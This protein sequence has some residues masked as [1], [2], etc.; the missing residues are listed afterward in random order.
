MDY[1][2]ICLNIFCLIVQSSMHIIFVSRFIGKKANIRYW[3]LYFFLLCVCEW[4]AHRM[5]FVWGVAIGIEL[6]ILY[7]VIRFVMN[8][9]NL[10]SW[11]SAILSIYISQLSFGLVNA[12]EAMLFYHFITQPVL[13]VLI[14]LATILALLLCGVCYYVVLKCVSFSEG[15]QTTE[16][17]LLLFPI[18][19]FFL[20][21]LYIM[22]INYTQVV[23]F[24]EMASFLESGKHMILFSLQAFGL[25]ALLCTL[26]SYRA[27][28]RGLQAK[29]T[30]SAVTQAAHAQKVYIA[31]AKMRLEK[32]RAFRHDINHHLSVLSGLCNHGNLDEVKRYL[33]K[34]NFAAGA[35]SFPYQTGN[36]IVDILLSEKLDL[37]KANQ[38]ETK[39]LLRL[40]NPCGVDDFDL[41]IIFANALDNA[42]EANQWIQGEKWISIS[43]EQQGD[44]YML[45]FQNTCAKGPLPPMGTGLSNIKS[46]AEKYQGTM[47]IEKEMDRF[48]LHILLNISLHIQDISNPKY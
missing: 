35:L 15:K 4:I 41:C 11:I 36:P 38:I 6:L 46:V 33:Q 1:F 5:G 14:I 48:S 22:Q 13:Y 31:Q 45:E 44:F 19:F 34:L 16:I 28:C 40:P 20:I 37:A 9:P 7:G 21:E 47:F 27:V 17:G 12:V 2:S 23:F 25:G 10:V 26:Y 29:A 18:L 39:V 8:Q 32:T 24:S 43:G 3:I 30:L 42:I